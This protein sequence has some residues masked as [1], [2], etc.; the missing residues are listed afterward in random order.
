MVLS[1]AKGLRSR[2]AP[3]ERLSQTAIEPGIR[4]GQSEGGE[5]VLYRSW[6]AQMTTGTNDKIRK[7]IGIGEGLSA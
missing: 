3:G 6:V 2:N 7:V 1:S 5:H 4:D